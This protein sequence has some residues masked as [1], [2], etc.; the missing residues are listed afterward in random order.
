MKKSLKYF[1][2]LINERL[3]KKYK[4]DINKYNNNIIE[5]IL[6]NDKSHLVAT[7]KDLLVINDDCEFFK[8]YYTTKEIQIILLKYITYYE[9]YN[10]LFP[11]YTAL[12]ESDYLYKNIN[13]KQRVIDEQQ[14]DNM[15]RQLKIEKE[16]E[17]NNAKNKEINTPSKTNSIFDLSN[18]TG[19]KIFDSNVYNS[20]LRST[21]NSCFSQF[22]IEK[23]N[24][25]FDSIKEIKGI[26]TEINDFIPEMKNTIKMDTPA[27]PMNNNNNIYLND[28]IFK[29]EIKEK[30][31]N[32]YIYKSNF[33]YNKFKNRNIS[34]LLFNKK[35]LK[36]SNTPLT[37]NKIN[38][39]SPLYKKVHIKINTFATIHKTTNENTKII[40][41]KNNNT[42]TNINNNSIVNNKTINNKNIIERKSFIYRK[43]SPMNQ[44]DL[45]NISSQKGINNS[46]STFKTITFFPLNQKSHFNQTNSKKINSLN[47]QIFSTDKKPNNL[48]LLEESN[49]NLFNTQTI[50]NQYLYSKR[51]INS[52]IYSNSQNNNLMNSL[53]IEHTVYTFSNYF[54]NKEKSDTIKSN[55]NIDQINQDKNNNIKKCVKNLKFSQKRTK[56]LSIKKNSLK[57]LI[58]PYITDSIIDSITNKIKKESQNHISKRIF[59]IIN[60]KG[61]K[62]IF[63]TNKKNTMSLKNHFQINKI[64]YN[65]NLNSKKNKLILSLEKKIRT[66]KDSIGSI[67][68]N[69]NISNNYEQT[70][71]IPMITYCKKNCL[72]NYTT[73]NSI[74][75]HISFMQYVNNTF[76]TIN[77][78]YNCQYLTNKED[79][80]KDNNVLAKSKKIKKKA[81]ENNLKNKYKFD[82]NNSIANKLNTITNFRNK[83]LVLNT[84]NH[85]K[86]VLIEKKKEN[87]INSNNYNKNDINNKSKKNNNAKIGTKNKTIKMKEYEKIKFIELQQSLDNNVNL[88]N[89]RTI[90]NN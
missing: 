71:K 35:I 80:N 57:N 67:N 77:N 20:I 5:N 65:K 89:N 30:K 22:G 50:N 25:K 58:K 12:P 84:N 56:S 38:F 63:K 82:I 37:N 9:K 68:F 28:N 75:K 61:K 81:S 29:K 17:K 46:S 52:E 51:R 45:K 66:S 54:F 31:F 16:K 21:N 23:N 40:N 39:Y 34:N 41:N 27:E 19:Q 3:H 47:N 85:K 15:I 79:I 62:K 6:V 4:T 11:N 59:N 44:S 49:I 32:K 2:K 70:N 53:P 7:F 74:K 83:K 73:P 69:T 48:N 18:N 33:C 64:K 36:I 60:D 78:T 90:N 43:F 10:F 8:K 87:K 72:N 1:E 42:N 55:K 13:R 24:E 26:I 76:S 14:N 86:K 88:I